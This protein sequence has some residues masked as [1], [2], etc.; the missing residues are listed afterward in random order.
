MT[1]A[2]TVENQPLSNNRLNKQ[3]K[4]RINAQKAYKLTQAEKANEALVVAHMGSQIIVEHQGKLIACSWRRHTADIAIND[5]V[6]IS[7]SSDG[8]AVV[9]AIYPRKNALYKWQGRK[10]KAIASN[11]DNLLIVIAV[12]PDWQTALVDRYIIVAQENEIQPAILLNKIDLANPE[13]QRELTQRLAPYHSLHIPIFITSINHNNNLA[14]LENWL[15]N[16]QTILCGQSGVGKS[17]LIRH[18]IPDADIWIQNI[19]EATGL[20]KHTTTNLRRYPVNANTAVID[21][22]GVRGFAVTHLDRDT[23]LTGF[24]DITPYANQCKFNDC[25]H[26]NEPDCGVQNALKS[27]KINPKRWQSLQQLLS[28]LPTE[29]YK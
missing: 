11:L 5:T 24:P 9:E 25:Q 10:T 2:K 4:R 20:G 22:P 1:T 15:D 6:A 18:L 28:E 29:V 7:Y 27:G 17:S 12:E 26:Q 3:Q 21:T 8:S 19:S 16:Q 13:K 14:S 23:I